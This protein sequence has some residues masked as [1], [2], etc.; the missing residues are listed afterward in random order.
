M[1]AESAYEVSCDYC[2]LPVPGLRSQRKAAAAQLEPAY[3]C[4]GC[5]FAA[6]ILASESSDGHAQRTFVKLGLAV[7][8]AMNVMVFSMALWS[9]DLYAQELQ[10]A[11][12]LADTLHQL[13]RYLALLFCLPVLALLGEPLAVGV[14]Q[15]LRRG[16]ITTDLLL[17]IGVAAAIAYSLWSVISGIGQIY[18]DVA[19]MILLFVTLG[20]WLEAQGKLRS[21]QALDALAK[22]LPETVHAVQ[23]SAVVDVP[24]EAVSIG[25][26]LRVFP[27][28]RFAVDGLIETGRASVD[29]QMLTG[30]SRAVV[31]EP[32]D[33][34]SSGTVNLDGDLQICVTAAAGT[35]TISR[36]LDLV[37]KSRRARAD[38]QRLADRV[39]A[40]F[41]PAVAIVALAAAWWHGSRA[42]L[43]AGILAGLAVTLIACPC[44]LGLATPMAIWIALGRAARGQVLF[45]NGHALEQLAGL[46]AMLFDKTGTLT[47]GDT[48]VTTF[49]AAENEDPDLVLQ[50]AAHMAAESNHTLSAAIHHHVEPSLHYGHV[51]QIRTLPGRGIQALWHHNAAAKDITFHVLLGSPQWLALA[52]L[53]ISN[54]FRQTLEEAESGDSPLSYVGWDGQVRGAFLFREQPRADAANALRELRQSG[55]HVAVVTGDRRSRAKRLAETLGVP[56]LAEQ[57]PDDKVAAIQ[58]ARERYGAVAMV[59]DG[60]NDAPALAASDV[61][62]AMGCGADLS[63]DSAAVCLLSNDLARLP[64]TINLSRKTLRIIRQNLCW[65]FSYNIVGM[66]LAAT[67]QLSPV[68]SAL[69]MVASSSFVISNSLRLNRFPEAA[70]R[71]ASVSD[72]GPAADAFNLQLAS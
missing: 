63:R 16:A 28:E 58:A 60:I 4:S 13:F 71:K 24:R 18:F 40:W 1:I 49:L 44:A 59:G 6:S 29:E 5:R 57:L 38:Y 43:D 11:G 53:T 25:D 70:S 22:L 12:P 9:R 34:I 31:R 67:G 27:G 66:G 52:G 33:A 50:I 17:L 23:D 41:V 37:R 3:C 10:A 61:G 55:V 46:R 2:G 7:F 26:T 15:A 65:A 51:D 64:W 47:T 62:I 48:T 56:V 30:E 36:M 45:R 42:G 32:G 20:R 54:C 35:E 19:C 69:A 8:F 72:S 68:F 14:W 21:G 39:S